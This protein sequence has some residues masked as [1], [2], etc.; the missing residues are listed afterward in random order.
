M[1]KGVQ[2]IAISGVTLLGLKTSADD[3]SMTLLPKRREGQE[4]SQIRTTVTH[5]RPLRQGFGKTKP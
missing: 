3:L 4:E 2:K 1:E 5:T